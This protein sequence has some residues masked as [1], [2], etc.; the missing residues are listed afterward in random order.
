[1]CLVT[2]LRTIL[3]YCTSK[4]YVLIIPACE[5]NI[6][7]T[8]KHVLKYFQYKYKFKSKLVIISHLIYVKRNS[9]CSTYIKLLNPKFVMFIR[10]V[11]WFA[12]ETFF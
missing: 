11:F 8:I 12:E 2:L 9:L 6:R 10:H 3:K 5:I 4:R 1:M 7:R